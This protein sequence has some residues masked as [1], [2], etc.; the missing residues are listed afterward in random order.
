MDQCV[1]YWIVQDEMKENGPKENGPVEAQQS[2]ATQLQLQDVKSVPVA[3]VTIKEQLKRVFEKLRLQI[4]EEF[5]EGNDCVDAM[6][7]QYHAI[8]QMQENRHLDEKRGLVESYLLKLSALEV[9]LVEAQNRCED[10]V[11]LQNVMIQRSIHGSFSWFYHRYWSQVGVLRSYQKSNWMSCEK[12]IS[13]QYH[14]FPVISRNEQ[15]I[16]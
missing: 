9:Q 13:I 10:L 16:K 12:R 7:L 4:V 3:G 11:Q 6:K 8:L 14:H 2:L 1:Y 5:L 15:P